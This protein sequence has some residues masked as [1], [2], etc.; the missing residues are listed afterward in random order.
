MKKYACVI[1]EDEPLAKEKMEVFV[2]KLSYLDL[3]ASF[4]NVLD[5]L[6]YLQNN[7]IDILFLDIQMDEIN[8]IQ[9]LETLNLTCSVILCSAHEEYARKAY[10]LNVLDYLLKP[11]GLDRFIKAVQKVVDQNQNSQE[12]KTVDYIFVK[13]ENRL[14]KIE[15]SDILFIEG[16]RDYRKIHT[17][18]EKIMTLQTFGELD[19]KLKGMDIIRVHKSFMVSISKIEHIERMRIK[20]GDRLIPVSDTY[21]EVFLSKLN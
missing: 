18:N 13:T 2:S 16:E 10:D 21:K 11:F 9:L 12:A 3:S 5:A 19:E 14:Q 7:T 4:D 17:V 1:V 6:N 8:G 20:I 15:L